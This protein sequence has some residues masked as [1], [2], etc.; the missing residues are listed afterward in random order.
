MPPDEISKICPDGKI[1]KLLPLG[2]EA[3]QDTMA[4]ALEFIEK[5]KAEN[6]FESTVVIVAHGTLNSYLVLAALGFPYKENFNF[7]HVN[8]GVSL[9]AYVEEDDGRIQTKLKFLND[10]SHLM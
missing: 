3:P 2:E 9:V 8:T 5:I 1:E 10:S 7:S 4:R 6:D